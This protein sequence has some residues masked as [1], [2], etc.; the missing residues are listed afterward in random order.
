M[1]C[2]GGVFNDLLLKRLYPKIIDLHP[3]TYLE[4]NFEPFF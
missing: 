1:V 3:V 4:N 2:V